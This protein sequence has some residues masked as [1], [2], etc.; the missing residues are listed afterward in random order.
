VVQALGNANLPIGSFEHAN[1]EI[2]VLGA[3]DRIGDVVEP[4]K[5]L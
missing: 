5:L 1:R 2:G 3:E 4:R